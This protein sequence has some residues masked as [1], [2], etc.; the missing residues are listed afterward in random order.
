MIDCDA[1]VLEIHGDEAV[2]DGEECEDRE[3]GDE[4]E[5]EGGSPEAAMAGALLQSLHGARG[6]LLRLCGM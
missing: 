5:E 2:V 6:P 3:S 4:D 1:F